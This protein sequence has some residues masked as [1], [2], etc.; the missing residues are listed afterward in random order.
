VSEI[1]P[2]KKLK[3]NRAKATV[4]LK[5][6]AKVEEAQFEENIEKYVK[7][8]KMV[9]ALRAKGI[10]FLFPIQEQCFLPIFEGRDLIG[11]DRTGSG[12]TLAFALP[13]LSR[14]RAELPKLRTFKMQ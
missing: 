8:A 2:Q 9:E 4:S 5:E 11:K 14:L 6:E 13:I 10:K 1:A 7:D 12:K 3:L